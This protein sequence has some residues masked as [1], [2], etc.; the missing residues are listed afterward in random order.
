MWTDMIVSPLTLNKNYSRW[1]LD[2][3]IKA[4]TTKF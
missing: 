2:L 4:T 1:L 3:N